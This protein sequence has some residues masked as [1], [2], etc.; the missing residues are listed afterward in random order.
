MYRGILFCAVS[1][2]FGVF[3]VFGQTPQ[4]IRIKSVRV[5]SLSSP[6]QVYPIPTPEGFE[7][8]IQIEL[9]HDADQFDVQVALINAKTKL[10]V[11]QCYE[12]SISVQDEGPHLDL[13]NWKH[14]VSDW[15]VIP[16]IKSGGFR[17]RVIS[18]EES[19][20]FPD[21]DLSSVMEEIKRQDPKWLNVVINA[22]SIRDFP[23]VI[24]VSVVSFRISAWVG[25]KWIP[26]HIVHCKRPM[27]C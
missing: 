26:I 3:A 13:V 18:K 5:V 22:K 21:V 1:I 19:K 14:Y 8:T 15:V 24:G 20:R 17:S 6:P 16:S 4:N 27:G 2:L 25:G 10:R 11:E 23:F 12:T 7:S 9:E